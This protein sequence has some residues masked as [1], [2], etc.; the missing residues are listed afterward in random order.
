MKYRPVVLGLLTWL[1][2]SA[3]WAVSGVARVAPTRASTMII[4]TTLSDE[5]LPDGDCALREAIR[6]ANQDVAVDAC[7]AGSGA[8]TIVLTPGTYTLSLV[9]RGEDDAATGDLDI[10]DNLA[11]TGAGAASTII[12]GQGNVGQGLDRVFHTLGAIS[13]TL[14]GVTIRKGNPGAGVFGGGILNQ[15]GALTLINSTIRDN[16]GPGGGGGIS[17]GGILTLRNSTVSGNTTDDHGGGIA[18]F[19]TLTLVNS[20][21]IS[22]TTN[23]S[24]G[25]L[26]NDPVG[27][28]TIANS[29]VSGNV[30]YGGGA[31]GGILN[32]IGTLTLTNST[33]GG[34]TAGTGGGL[35]NSGTVSLNNVTFT[36]NSAANGGGGLYHNVGIVNFTNTLIGG[37]NDSSGG[38]PDCAGTLTS[39]GYNLIQST[40]GCII[41]GTA[42]GNKTGVS[43]LLGPLQNNGGRTPSHALLAGSPAIDAGN[44]AMPGSGG[45]ACEARDQRDGVRPYGAACDIG[46]YEFG[47]A[48]YWLYLP[49]ITRGP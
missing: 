1:S 49:L 15:G 42:T 16:T 20:L 21:I 12:D 6:A 32:V 7:P 31:G 30:V 14:S 13:V 28:L 19:G 37:N 9:G 43:P 5:L 18:N 46:A 4:V 38:A 41:S 26:F 3:L 17:N 22:N 29:T 47:A 39:Q 36:G 34:N 40:T 24:G 23:N 33:I 35:Y 8:D 27:T 11:I 25:G 45:N 48:V 2:L 44:P 10:T